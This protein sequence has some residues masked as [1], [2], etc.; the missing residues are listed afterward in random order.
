M[1]K[2]PPPPLVSL[3]SSTDLTGQGSLSTLFNS[4]TAGSTKSSD[5]N[6]TTSHSNF[7]PSTSNLLDSS[8]DHSSLLQM[9]L[10]AEKSQELIWSNI[11]CFSLNSPL[12]SSCIPCLPNAMRSVFDD[13]SAPSSTLIFPS[14]FTNNY[15]IMPNLNLLSITGNSELTENDIKTQLARNAS[16]SHFSTPL[17]NLASQFTLNHWDSVQEITA[18]LLFMVIHWIKS[19]PTF[20]TLS[21]R[22]QVNDVSLSYFVSLTFFLIVG[23]DCTFGRFLE[24]SF[25]LKHGSIVNH[26]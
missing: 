3:S 1:D 7:T 21:N 16:L 8:L 2:F 15:P 6:L 10:N 9:L 25:S 13:S 19:L 26:F 11:R 20:Q 22:D 4:S 12:S 23:S 24:G 18:R 17:P 14:F 5:C